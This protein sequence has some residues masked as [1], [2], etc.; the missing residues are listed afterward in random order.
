MVEARS[1]A[2]WRAYFPVGVLSR[3]VPMR[4][5]EYWFLMLYAA[6]VASAGTAAIFL[7]HP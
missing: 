3:R 6:V 7:L 4:Y 1:E 5:M 2:N